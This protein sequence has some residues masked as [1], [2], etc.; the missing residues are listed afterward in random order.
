MNYSDYGQ[1]QILSPFVAFESTSGGVLSSTQHHVQEQNSVPNP[2]RQSPS[3]R[4]PGRSRRQQADR[5]KEIQ[6]LQSDV[7]CNSHLLTNHQA[8][9]PTKLPQAPGTDA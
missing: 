5:A 8:L 6:T 2:S 3:A 4:D 1:G 9:G 7:A